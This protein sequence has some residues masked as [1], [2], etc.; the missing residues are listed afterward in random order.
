MISIHIYKHEDAE[1][2]GAARE[3]F[4]RESLADYGGPAAAEAYQ[5]G[6]AV[7]RGPHGKPR[8]AAPGLAG[9][10]FSVSHSGSYLA[11]AFSDYEVGIDIEHTERRHSDAERYLAIARRF[12]LPDESAYVA[13]YSVRGEASAPFREGAPEEVKRRFFRIWT[14]KEAAV[15]YTGEGI[16]RGFGAFSALET[17]DKEQV[18]PAIPTHMKHGAPIAPLIAS[19]ERGVYLSIVKDTADMVCAVCGR[20]REFTVIEG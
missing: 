13:G 12:F 1:A 10:H 4:F 9:A 19:P 17:P 7:T 20:E 5:A 15:K 18:A 14:A 11:I 3:V 16:A 6:L 8:F 2:R